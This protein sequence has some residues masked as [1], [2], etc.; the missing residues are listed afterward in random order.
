MLG[1]PID[2]TI[3]ET[4]NERKKV[5]KRN[6]N[7][8]EST[9]GKN[10][11]KEIQKSI[12]RTPYISMFSSPKLISSTGNTDNQFDEGDII[13]SNQEYNRS[14]LNS[15]FNPINY[16]LG[17][18]TDIQKEGGKYKFKDD[19]QYSS[20]FKPKPGVISLTSEYKSTSNVHFTREV[21][22]TWRC[23]HIDDLERLSYRFLTL[24]KLVYIEWGWAYPDEERTS[25][26]TPKNLKRISNPTKLREDVIDKGKGNFDAVLGL[27]RN[28]EWSS[29]GGG[30]ECRTDIISQGVDIFNQ[31]IN[32]DTQNV[33]RG[34]EIYRP[35]VTKYYNP[36]TITGLDDL[37]DSMENKRILDP[38]YDYS[39]GHSLTSTD[40][41]Y[42]RTGQTLPINMDL[43][44]PGVNTNIREVGEFETAVSDKPYAQLG[45]VDAVAQAFQRQ[46]ESEAQKKE[47]L[48]SFTMDNLDILINEKLMKVSPSRTKN[49]YNKTIK[50]NVSESSNLLSEQ[51]QK[52][53]NLYDKINK[54]VTEEY[55]AQNFE[56]WDNSSLVKDAGGSRARYKAINIETNRRFQEQN[57]GKSLNQHIEQI[58]KQYSENLISRPVEIKS[59]I[60]YNKNFVQKVD[61]GVL[62]FYEVKSPV[63]HY[64]YEEEIKPPEYNSKQTWVRWG[65]F[66]DNIL[67]RY[68]GR[69]NQ[70]GEPI[71]KIRSV[72][73]EENNPVQEKIINHKDFLTPDINRFI[74]PGKF[75]LGLNSKEEQERNSDKIKKY[76]DSYSDNVELEYAKLFVEVDDANYEIIRGAIALNPNITLDQLQDVIDTKDKDI[77]NIDDLKQTSEKLKFL[78]LLEEVM[79]AEPDEETETNLQSRPVDG[80]E[81]QDQQPNI[82]T[83]GYDG[84]IRRAP[85]GIQSFNS[86]NENE[87]ILRNVFINV[88]H[89]QEIFREKTTLGVCVN[90]LL[91]SFNGTTPLFN[92]IPVVNTRENEGHILFTEQRFTEDFKPETQRQYEFPIKITE[93]FVKSTN[94]ASDISAEGTKILLSQQFANMPEPVIDKKTGASISAQIEF[95]RLNKV[96]GKYTQFNKK[97]E[98]GIEPFLY[99]GAYG[100]SS[101]QAYGQEQG[102]Y[103]KPLAVGKGDSLS[104]AGLSPDNLEKIKLRNKKNN[105]KENEKSTETSNNIKYAID[106]PGNY[107]ENGYLKSK[108]ELQNTENLQGTRFKK[109]PND[110]FGLLFLTNTMSMDGIAGITPGNIY[111]SQYL[112]DKF[113][114]NCYFFIQNASQTIDSSTWT[115]EITGRVLF[116]YK[117]K[118]GILGADNILQA[119]KDFEKNN[120]NRL[121]KTDSLSNN[122]TLLN[123]GE[124]K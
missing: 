86:E 38:N 28:F 33:T 63:K 91:E 105:N 102:D 36:D 4:L 117:T 73:N 37:A 121:D 24:N 76:E 113:K 94:L 57:N 90:R 51:K 25:F 82:Q 55:D 100:L 93:S 22:I 122:Q 14:D 79:K 109:S 54:E 96:D 98:N 42:E 19:E 118:S 74:F 87:G 6:K 48:F 89:L 97:L 15:T 101:V 110:E 50:T 112:P 5:L 41:Y 47:E 43:S 46:E 81:P 17:L 31:R 10:P 35:G 108:K 20:Q 23:H 124:Y 78:M 70:D 12:V 3:Q 1:Y 32:D 67:N 44:V 75:K 84:G 64:I 27:I 7:P 66:E 77:P 30:F 83:P 99:K 106:V 13:L 119:R 60:Y 53:Q 52:F 61:E 80:P 123:I 9:G 69:I 21:S 56:N 107:T 65:W 116:K 8:Y 62:P 72:R 114:D 103:T 34:N 58:E 85:T 59:N 71:V 49:I 39:T 2:P 115:T 88:S 26:I 68:F 18:Y 11:S 16:G 120:S 95:D 29:D 92:L 45:D 40:E 111:T 104:L